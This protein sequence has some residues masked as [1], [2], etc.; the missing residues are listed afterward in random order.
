MSD[1]TKIESSDDII[2]GMGMEILSGRII[3]R[4]TDNGVVVMSNP[5]MNATITSTKRLKMDRAVE[6]VNLL[7]DPDGIRSD[8][9]ALTN[10]P[11][12]YV[13]RTVRNNIARTST[14]SIRHLPTRVK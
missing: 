10:T 14:G 12:M 3:S 8:V 13:H 6:M 5:N 1:Y 9:A 11:D 7:V 2:L 4:V